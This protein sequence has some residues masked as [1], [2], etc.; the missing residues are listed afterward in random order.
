MSNDKKEKRKTHW[1]KNPNKNYLGHWDLPNGND[2]TLTIKSAEW[3][4][5]ENPKVGKDDP[6]RLEPKR[7]IRWVENAKPMICNE[8]NAA[9]IVKSTGIKFMED[10]GGK[11]ITLYVAHFKKG[12]I[13]T[14]CIRVREVVKDL[15]TMIKE[16]KEM[17]SDIKQGVQGKIEL[18]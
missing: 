7:V 4:K 18:A 13:S 2:L 15:K 3:E 16:V 12:V 8:T 1:L 11:K 10:S 9:M 5:V 17:K 14:D 6:K